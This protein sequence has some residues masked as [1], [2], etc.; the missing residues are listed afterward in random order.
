MKTLRTTIFWL[1]FRH[2]HFRDINCG[3]C[4]HRP[5]QEHRCLMPHWCD[6]WVCEGGKWKRRVD[7]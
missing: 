2:F 5:M 4:Y 3:P 1:L 7:E 6:C